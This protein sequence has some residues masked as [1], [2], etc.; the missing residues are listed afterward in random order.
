MVHGERVNEETFTTHD[1]VTSQTIDPHYSEYAFTV[2]K[3]GY[4]NLY[5]QKGVLTIQ[6]KIKSFV[7]KIA[8]AS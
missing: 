4:A 5:D 7:Q 6:W 8:P 2:H 1:L 3:A